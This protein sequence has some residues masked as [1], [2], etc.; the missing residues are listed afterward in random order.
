MADQ[1]DL[2]KSAAQRAARDREL[3]DVP[4]KKFDKKGWPEGV[5]E[6]GLDELDS[7][8]VDR[9]GRLYWDGV[10]VKVS[11]R[12]TNWQSAGAVLVTLATVAAAIAEGVQA[13]YAI[14]DHLP[15]F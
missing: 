14:S 6:V 7:L 9:Q 10:P 12:L 15:H 11:G 4:L 5:R 13:W 3:S 2:S 8:G 1:S